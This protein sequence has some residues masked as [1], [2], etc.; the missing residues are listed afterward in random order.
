MLVMPM[1]ALIWASVIRK[2]EGCLRI[3]SKLQNGGRKPQILV[4][5]VPAAIWVICILLAIE[6]HRTMPKPLRSINEQQMLVIPMLTTVWVCAISEGRGVAQD[7]SKA[8]ECGTSSC[9][10]S[11]PSLLQFGFGLF[12]G[13][14]VPQSDSKAAECYQRAADLAGY[15]ST[16]SAPSS[17]AAAAAG[18]PSAALPPPVSGAL[19]SFI[20]D[21]S[22]A[23]TDVQLISSLQQ[24]QHSIQ[25]PDSSQ[26]VLCAF[27]TGRPDFEWCSV[28]SYA[29]SF[30]FL[31]SSSSRAVLYAGMGW[32]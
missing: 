25:P 20:T 16:P 31:C 1:L 28:W 11:R 15:S 29:P 13:K 10:W 24:Y 2:A 12:A 18:S 4:I 27:L 8:A 7:Y 3:I 9:C 17:A 14:G 22:R 23:A 6:S 21:Q 19:F 30:T 5:L 32:F 26:M